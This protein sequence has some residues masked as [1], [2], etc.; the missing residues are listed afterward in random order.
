MEK[1]K[2]QE[3]IQYKIHDSLFKDALSHPS[4]VEKLI[5]AYTPAEI[6]ELIDWTTLKE[7]KTNFVSEQ[8]AQ[9]YSD[10][11]YK[12]RLLDK[13]TYLYFLLESQTAPDFYFPHRK[14][15][16]RLLITEEHLKT[17]NFL[18][19]ILTLCLY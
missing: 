9:N 8:L 2:E 4:E 19:R 14:E 17:E 1:D 3:G 5:R 6:V 10:V 15:K 13:K 7:C 16:Y 11:I 18:P 12:C